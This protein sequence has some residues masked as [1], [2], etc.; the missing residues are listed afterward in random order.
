MTNYLPLLNKPEGAVSWLA[1]SC[2]HAPLHDKK[3]LAVIAERTA[4]WAPD[5]IIHLGDLH[6]ADSA[7]RW[8]SEYKWTL[9]HEYYDANFEVLKPLRLA[10]PNRNAECIFL[11]GNHDDNLLAI[12]RI[13]PKVRGRCD[14]QIPQ[15]SKGTKTRPPVW[16]NE[17]LLT[18]W[19]VPTKYR[20]NRSEGV[21]RIGATIFAHGYE[22]GASSDEAQSLTLGWPYGLVVTGHTHRPTEGAARQA[23]KSKTL[24]LPYWYLNA[25]MTGTFDVPYMHRKRQSQWGQAMCY[26][27]SMPIASPRFSRSWD[28]YCELIEPYERN[29]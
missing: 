19:T 10:N 6:E 8:P 18:H 29:W 23:M 11:P 7:S 20:Y 13:A 24:P 22:A 21:Y 12:D 3:A 17:E 28:G 25:G 27:W 2:S 16:L 26:G 1:L 9:E 15:Y 5:K 4:E 14:W